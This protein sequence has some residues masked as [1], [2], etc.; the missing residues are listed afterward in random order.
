MAGAEE[1]SGQ[2]KTAFLGH[3]NWQASEAELRELRKEVTF[4]IYTEMDDLDQ[5]ARIV[6]NL[7]SLLTKAY[8]I[9]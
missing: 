7:F 5:V 2:I 8:T 6:D 4:A 1:V 9:K 3:P